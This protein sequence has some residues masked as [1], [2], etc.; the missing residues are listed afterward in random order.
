MGLFCVDPDFQGKGF[1]Q[2]LFTEA[3]GLGRPESPPVATGLISTEV[4]E[5]FYLKFGFGKAGK[6]NVGVMSQ[7]RGGSIMFY[8]RYLQEQAMG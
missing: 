4:R 1:G 6:A 7:V 8:Q 5:R 2:A 3:V